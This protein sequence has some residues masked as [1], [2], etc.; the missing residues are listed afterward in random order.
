MIKVLETKDHEQGLGLRAVFP[1]RRPRAR[2]RG[3]SAP[4]PLIERPDL[5]TLVG[6]VGQVPDPHRVRGRRYRIGPLLAPCLVIV[7]SGPQS[8]AAIARFSADSDFDLPTRLGLTRVTPN[9]TTL[10]RLLTR[11]EGDALND[12]ARAWIARDATDPVDGRGDTLAG[13]AIDRKA[14]CDS[15]THDHTAVSP[16]EGLHCPT[17]PGLPSRVQA[18]DIKRRRVNGMTGKVQRKTFYAATSL[19]PDH[20]SPARLA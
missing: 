8:V 1:N 11:L 17:R 10:R 3:C 12:A 16:P 4:V 9:T 13:L 5:R 2:P 19:R 20:A 7:L 18:V 15:R 14:V 6:V